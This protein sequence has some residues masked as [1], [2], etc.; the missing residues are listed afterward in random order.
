MSL[1]LCLCL[2]V[3][4]A[5]PENN[6]AFN[7]GLAR[8][9]LS[10]HF[11]VWRNFTTK[12][13]DRLEYRAKAPDWDPTVLAWVAHLPDCQRLRLLGAPVRD[14]DLIHLH[15]AKQLR[16]ITLDGDGITDK[17]FEHL[18]KL[19][20]LETIGIGGKITRHAMPWIVRCKNLRVLGID[21]PDLQDEDVEEF[22]KCPRLET[23][24]LGSSTAL[25]P[26]GIAQLGRL[27][28]LKTL[29]LGKHI[30]VDDEALEGIANLETLET[31]DI[32]TSR[33]TDQGLQH[34]AKLPAL[35]R[36]EITRSEIT[37]AGFIAFRSLKNL[38]YLKIFGG[39]INGEGLVHLENLDQLKE[40]VLPGTVDNAPVIKFMAKQPEMFIHHGAYFAAQA[41]KK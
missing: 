12:K 14:A 16:E 30:Q 41:N 25:S 18:A 24:L 39:E 36:L 28:G 21:L 4:A 40:L 5:P 17:A 19:E 13:F 8:T 7:P 26:R 2:L 37:D 3:C 35:T 9:K 11:E 6:P 33:I 31:L 22:K 15:G 23:L 1:T 20:G 38:E 10:P 32:S 27:T 34:V 29:K